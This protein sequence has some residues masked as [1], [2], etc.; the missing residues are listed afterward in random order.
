MR[1][2][3]LLDEVVRILDATPRELDPEAKYSG[4]A[5]AIAS[6][7]KN[8][9]VNHSNVFDIIAIMWPNCTMRIAEDEQ[10]GEF[11]TDYA[12]QQSESEEITA[13]NVTFEDDSQGIV[14]SQR[15]RSIDWIVVS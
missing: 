13:Y 14:V 15:G 11:V 6:Y 4:E 10:R 5:R 3:M 7:V 9:K 8:H 12:Q 2:S 1:T